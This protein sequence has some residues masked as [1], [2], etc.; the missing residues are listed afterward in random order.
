MISNIFAVLLAPFVLG[1]SSQAQTCQLQPESSIHTSFLY[2]E[3]ATYHLQTTSG[4]AACE[5]YESLST[6]SAVEKRSGLSCLVEG[7]FPVLLGES[8][9]CYKFQGDR[10]VH[11]RCEIAVRQR[12]G[13]VFGTHSNPCDEESVVGV[14]N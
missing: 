14:R 4:K 9:T 2:L 10:A 11:Y 7:D 1:F 12:D 6:G 5:T 13:R 8:I 3:E